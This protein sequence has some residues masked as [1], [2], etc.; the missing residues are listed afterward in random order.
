M[1]NVADG[2][3]R[4]GP[5]E[6]TKI[7]RRIRARRRRRIAGGAA[8]LV[9]SACVALAIWLYPRTDQ[10]PDFAGISCERVMDL[11]DA[12]M[13]KQLAAELQG[14]VRRH[15]ELCPNC[16]GMFHGMPAVSH[17]G[18]NETHDQTDHAPLKL[19]RQASRR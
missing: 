19:A 12:Y 17:F 16:Q 3:T 8:L 7:A 4:C 13:K 18:P 5:N 9:A 1:T 2:W 15:I 14:Q 6:I 10:G 11:S